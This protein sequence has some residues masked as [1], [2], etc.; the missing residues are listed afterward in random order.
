VLAQAM[1]GQPIDT[2]RLGKDLKAFLD[3]CEKIAGVCSDPAQRK[4]LMDSIGQAKQVQY[5]Y[6]RCRALVPQRKCYRDTPHTSHWKLFLVL[7][8]LFLCLYLRSHH[9]SFAALKSLL[10]WRPIRD[11]VPDPAACPMCTHG[12]TQ[13]LE[14]F[15]KA[16]AH[17][18][19]NPNDP[20][21]KSA[22]EAAA[23][24]LNDEVGTAGE[25]VLPRR[26]DQRAFMH[27]IDAAG[28]AA[29]SW[30]DEGLAYCTVA[31]NVRLFLYVCV[32]IRPSLRACQVAALRAH[33]LRVLAAEKERALAQNAVTAGA[34]L[35]AAKAGD[36]AATA[37]HALAL[38]ADAKVGSEPVCEQ[39][40]P[41]LECLGMSVNRPLKVER[42][43]IHKLRLLARKRLLELFRQELAAVTDAALPFVGDAGKARA[44]QLA[45]QAV[46]SGAPLLCSA[47]KAA[48]ANKVCS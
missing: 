17:F 14:A 8:S 26:D 12:L 32:A 6:A 13:T 9:P 39:S 11:L 10:A 36:A 28:H 4:A 30:R 23:K 19:A 15:N 24:E 5:I 35:D 16:A 42:V 44:V 27:H 1:V 3:G 41:W 31:L 20:E 38:A 21:A 25:Y 29:T 47:A 45:A 37:S 48:A 2:D 40:I 7:L 34:L 22:Y 46:Q 33:A 43:M 18:K